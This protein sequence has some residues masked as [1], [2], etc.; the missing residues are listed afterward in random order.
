MKKTPS[1]VLPQ[2]LSR[3]WQPKAERLGADIQ[4]RFSEWSA[5]LGI[6]TWMVEFLWSRGLRSCSEMDVFLSPNLRYLAPLECWP[7][8][9]EAADILFDGIVQGK[10]LVIWGDYDVDGVTSTALVMEILAG[11]GVVARHH[12]P[13]RTGEGY[14]L[15]IPFIEQLFSE[16]VRMLLTVDCG[17][18]G[19]AA[20]ARARELGM[21]VVISDHHLP[22]S[23]ELPCAH[24]IV[25]PRLQDC[26][27]ASL[28][29]VGVAFF[30]MAALNVRLSR[31]SGV[32]V[33]IR[34]VLDLVAL[35]TL[36]DLV[37]V[38]GQNRI[39]VKNGL[40]LLSEGKRPGIA[41][42]KEVAGIRGSAELGTMQVVFGLA[43]RV[44]A[45]GRLG[46][47]ESALELLLCSNPVR[48]AALAQELDALNKERRK[49]EERI[50][51]EAMAQAHEQEDRAGLVLFNPDW[52]PG[53]IGIVA[54]RVV[55][56]YHKPTLIFCEENG[57]CKGSGR[58]IEPFDLHAG[59]TACAELFMRFGGH[60]QAAGMALQREN[61]EEL[62][63]RFDAVVRE[64]LGAEQ[65]VPV[66]PIDCELDFGK[67]ADFTFLKE[68]ELL[69]PFGNGN[70]EPVFMS[71]P[72]S[73]KSIKP[74]GARGEHAT[75]ELNDA[76]SGITLRAKA[77]RL[78]E[79]FPA[80][81]TDSRICIAYTP[82]IDRYNGVAN[83]DLRLR[84]WKWLT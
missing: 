3:L 33:D 45:A 57:C 2:R 83:V 72:L 16:G 10:P 68:I 67:A 59:L 29:G 75:L 4:A 7:G 77:W 60:R 52:H 82:R 20:V 6:S 42:L 69:Q 34:Q 49:E 11:H 71:P 12:I 9:S 54:S 13:K 50:V 62:K 1:V 40:L 8:V 23:G 51:V 15:N 18:A 73:L 76:C 80:S 48:A 79:H 24:A 47:A 31:W 53:V 19:H 74:L 56:A 81:K 78:A 25:N 63:Q 35:G 58:S 32:K 43:P 64:A 27:C 84:D 22:E 39:L 65:Q 28:A 70:P 66:L 36:A 55:E 26:P 46:G 5:K 44:N 37:T 17:V 41:A 21:I 14:G 61:L 30:L 38:T